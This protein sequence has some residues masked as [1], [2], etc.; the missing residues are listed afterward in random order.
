MQSISRIVDKAIKRFH[1]TKE[2]RFMI[3]IDSFHCCVLPVNYELI[4]R[5]PFLEINVDEQ[6]QWFTFIAILPTEME[7][8]T[9][10]QK[11]ESIFQ[12]INN[13]VKDIPF[14]LVRFLVE[15]AE[16]NIV[17]C[18]NPY[19]HILSSKPNWIVNENLGLACYGHV[20]VV[21]QLNIYMQPLTFY[22]PDIV[23]FKT[24][25]IHTSHTLEELSCQIKNSS[26]HFSCYHIKRFYNNVRN[27][28]EQERVFEVF[29]MPCSYSSL[30]CE[31]VIDDDDS[32]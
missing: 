2:S 30:E 13:R 31:I 7:M 12:E 4:R 20:D 25:K 24:F 28:S 27:F 8:S 11:I 32:F 18:G 10:K 22:A 3:P 14:P 16:H 17:E 5:S 9:A 23:K 26:E 6:L 19:S 15:K 29:E 1:Q 21:V